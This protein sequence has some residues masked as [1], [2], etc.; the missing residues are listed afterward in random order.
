MPHRF[1]DAA[2]W[3]QR[4]DDPERDAWQKPDAVV[5]ALALPADAVVADVGAGTGYF[6]VRLARSLRQGRV[7]ALDVESSMVRYVEQRARAEGLDNLAARVTPADRADVDAGT[8]LVLV[9]DTFHHI[10]DRVAYFGA[11]RPRLS[12]RGRVAIVDFRVDSE[13]GPPKAHKLAPELVTV[14]LAKAGYALVATH[15]FL[16]DQY[17]LVFAPTTTVR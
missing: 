14:E 10:A 7:L 16:P 8:D 9:V 3:A 12:P 5:A 1:D 11:L 15:D 13:R 2:F 4:F 17:L 6:A